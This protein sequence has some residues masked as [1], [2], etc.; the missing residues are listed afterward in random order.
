MTISAMRPRPP[1]TPPTIAPM[2]GLDLPFVSAAGVADADGVPDIL[3]E[4][5]LEDAMEV[6]AGS[7]EIAVD[8]SCSL[9]PRLGLIPPGGA[10]K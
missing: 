8:A 3:D 2:G 10:S 6:G 4:P 5:M 1:S 9:N 7:D